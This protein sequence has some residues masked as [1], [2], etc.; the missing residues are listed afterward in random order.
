MG[1]F[2]LKPPAPPTYEVDWPLVVGVT[3]VILMVV[4]AAVLILFLY[5]GSEKKRKARA[6]IE[7][8]VM[9]ERQLHAQQAHAQQVYQAQAQQAYHAQQ[10]QAQQAYAAAQQAQAA[11]EEEAQRLARREEEKQRRIARLQDL[12]ARFGLD[13]AHRII[14]REIWKGQSAAALLEARGKPMDVDERVMKNKTRHVYKYNP[15]GVNR[16]ALRVTLED[17]VVV[18]WE[19]KS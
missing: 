7:A 2:L 8:R 4:G 13:D 15:T 1:I 11:A 5:A 3:M 19:D 10:M 16:F 18:G 17:D 9:H 12:A 14:R 6:A